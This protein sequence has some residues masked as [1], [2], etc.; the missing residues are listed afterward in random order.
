MSTGEGKWLKTVS[1]KYG[2]FVFS[3]TAFKLYRVRGDYSGAL[4]TEM[5]R[6]LPLSESKKSCWLTAGPHHCVNTLTHNVSTALDTS[7]TFWWVELNNFLHS[8]FP[9]QDTVNPSL[10]E[11]TCR[12]FQRLLN[13]I[14]S[15][16]L[17][18]HTCNDAT[19]VYYGRLTRI[20]V[21]AILQVMFYDWSLSCC[22]HIKHFE[23]CY[24]KTV[25]IM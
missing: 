20:F 25:S 12:L 3:R 19:V 4:K 23:S 24:N 1:P 9:S 7:P 13:L 11:W 22:H 14:H 10:K 21:V 2:Q 5:V 16:Y 17:M 6:R 8:V 15:D 18:M